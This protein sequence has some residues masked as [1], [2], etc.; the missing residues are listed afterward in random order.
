MIFIPARRPPHKPT[1]DL[2]PAADRAR[3]VRL[4]VAGRPGLTVSR[5][6]LDRRGPSYTL[7][8]IRA[9]R[10]RH[11]GR[12]LFF[13][14]GAD[15]VREIPTWHRWREVLRAVRF[16][17]VARPGAR[18]APLAGHRRR[19]VLVRARGADVSASRLRAR[20]RAGRPVGRDLPAPVRAHIRRRDLYATP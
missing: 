10:R 8:T 4:L 12:E 5:V 14:V 2:A 1:R 17:V 9:M 19:F 16:A 11:P 3:M 6:E 13:I 7:D 18:L 20:L 15:S